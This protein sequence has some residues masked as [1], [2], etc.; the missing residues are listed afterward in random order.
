LHIPDSPFFQHEYPYAANPLSVIRY[1]FKQKFVL[2]HISQNR[3]DQKMK[4]HASTTAKIKRNENDVILNREYDKIVAILKSMQYEDQGGAIEVTIRNAGDVKSLLSW[5]RYLFNALRS[6]AIQWKS[7]P[8]EETNL[9]SVHSS[10]ELMTFLRVY[11]HEVNYWKKLLI[12]IAVLHDTSPI[13]QYIYLPC[14]LFD[15]QQVLTK[16]LEEIVRWLFIGRFTNCLRIWHVTEMD[17]LL[18]L[19]NRIN[20]PQKFFT[21]P[22]RTIFPPTH[23]LALPKFEY[24]KFRDHFALQD[25]INGEKEMLK[26]KPYIGKYNA[27]DLSRK[28]IHNVIRFQVIYLHF[29]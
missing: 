14:V 2:I 23:S 7:T 24:F 21:F 29:F 9:F 6:Y 12:D 19:Q 22:K 16:Y 15:Q 28:R 25:S 5:Y 17:K 4:I 10:L 1:C 3:N 18:K 27:C 20:F 26:L 13:Q 11:M 8:K